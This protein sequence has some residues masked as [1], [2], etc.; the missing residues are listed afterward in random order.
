MKKRFMSA[1]ALI[2]GSMLFLSA[3]GNNSGD[4]APVAGDKTAK[5]EEKPTELTV[6]FPIFGAVPKDLSLVQDSINQ[7]TQKKINATVKLTPISFGNWDQQIN[8]MLSSSEKLDLMFVGGNNYSSYVSKGQIVAL[9]KLLEQHGQGIAKAMDPAYLN[10]AKISGSIYAIPTVRDFAA[11]NGLTMRKDL[12][13][14]YQIDVSKIRTLD[15]VEATLKTIKEKEPNVTPLIPGNIGRT[16]LDS[17]RTFDMLGDS[18][19]VLPNFDNNLKVVNL[20]E[21]EEYAQFVKKMRNWYTSGLILKDAATNK[22]SQFDLIKSNRGFAYFS[23]MKPGFEQQETKSSGVPVVTASLLQPVS[24]TTN[25][26]GVMWG[27]PINSKTPEKAMD[28]L[29]LMYSDKDIVNLF[30]WGV[31]GK[32]YVKSDNVIDYPQGVDAKT[33]GYSLNMGYMF[34]NQFLSYVFKGDDP[35]IWEKMDQFN[36]S[37]LKSKALGFTFD[38][39]PVKAEYAA[40]TN[41]VTQYKLPL[42]TGG[43]DPEKIL[44]EFISKL[45]SAGI[46]KIIAEKQKQLDEWAKKSK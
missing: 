4:T 44:P 6:A 32:H 23:N 35:K 30:D 39:N 27:I 17:Y 15:D 28:F 43:V 18:L 42:E 3:C 33:S 26:T 31:E 36:K 25:V 2:I 45:K 21:T 20:Y 37:A 24:T 11:Y 34:G 14:K 7:I 22:T 46:D 5:P 41:V 12:V 10:A 19:G 13:D 29:N 40:V 16:M 9:S 8:L 38:A 1:S